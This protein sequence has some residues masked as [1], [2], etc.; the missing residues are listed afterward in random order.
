MDSLQE[1]SRF[2]DRLVP[3]LTLVAIRFNLPSHKQISL[4]YNSTT[5]VAR[6][7]A[8]MGACL[9]GLAVAGSGHSFNIAIEKLDHI[10]LLTNN[11][12]ES[13]KGWDGKSLEG[14]LH[15]IHEPSDATTVYV[16]GA[17]KDLEQN[18]TTFDLTQAFRIGSPAQELAYAVN[19]SI[20]TLHERKDDFVALGITSIVVQD[21]DTLLNARIA[22]GKILVSYVDQDLQPVAQNI[23]QQII[24]SL[25][26]GKACFQ[27]DNTTCET[28]IVDPN[29]TRQLALEYN[30]MKPNGYPIV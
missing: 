22:F 2:V 23:Q 13:I 25:Q 9:V 17:T 12:T 7:L 29:R 5:M 21:I 26:Q 19:A 18:P 24:D 30:A 6:S 11:V 28:A 15:Q 10:K 16:N 4:D 1:S 20:A 14:A 3:H 27:N 8:L